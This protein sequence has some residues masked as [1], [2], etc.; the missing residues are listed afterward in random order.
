MNCMQ[1][2]NGLGTLLGLAQLILYFCY[3]GSTPNKPSDDSNSMELP[4]TAGDQ[5]KN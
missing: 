2:P 3:Y 5:G 1:I 4:V